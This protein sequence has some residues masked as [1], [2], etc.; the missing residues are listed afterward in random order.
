MFS[1]GFTSLSVSLL[2]L[3]RS[4]SSSLCTVFD[5]ISSTIDEVLLINPSANVF[6]F[7]DF[8]VHYE[9]WL[10]YSGGADGPGELTQ[11]TLLRW[12]TFLRGSQTV[13]L[14]ALLFWTY[15][16]LLMLVSLLQR[17]SLHCEILIMFL[18]QF[19]LTFHQIHSGM[20][21]FILCWLGWCS[22]SFER[23]FMAGYL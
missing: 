16:F 20:P 13:I 12:L 17:L 1:T 4:P 5:S 10:T 2:F 14:I 11:M 15:F 6:V 19:S 22:W 21:F 9:D 8:N 7:R 23:C 18:S 3:Y